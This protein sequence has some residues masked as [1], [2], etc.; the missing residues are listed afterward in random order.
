VIPG[1]TIDRTGGRYD[2]VEL[3][4]ELG[5]DTGDQN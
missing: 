2:H 1:W 4:Q 3:Y 5:R